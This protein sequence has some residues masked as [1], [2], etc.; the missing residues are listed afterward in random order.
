MK[1][2]LI[3]IILLVASLSYAEPRVR[4]ESWAKPIIG[5][6]LDN[7]YSVDDGVF[8]SE[9]PHEKNVADLRLLGIRE[10]LNLREFHSDQ[11]DITDADFVLHR[12]RIN[13]GNITEDQVIEALR[14]IRNRK[15]PILVHCWHGSDRTGTV[16][17]AYRI[18]FNGWSKAQA[19]DEMTNGN[20]GYHAKIYPG[21]ITFIEN[22][23]I[24]RI[25]QVLESQADADKANL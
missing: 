11:D 18:V 23:D 24:D 4:P 8:R 20:F 3:L 10:I 14:I 17:A 12:I 19:I 21:L 25:K 7:L 9:Q 6:Q 5:A 15:A 22:L 13:T 16:I 2:Y 1:K